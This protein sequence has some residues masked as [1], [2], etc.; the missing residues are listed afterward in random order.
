MIASDLIA[1]EKRNHCSP[2]ISSP[3]STVSTRSRHLMDIHS[4]LAQPPDWPNAEFTR[5]RET[6]PVEQHDRKVAFREVGDSAAAE[7]EVW[8]LGW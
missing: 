7:I 1:S 8:L 3:F 6:Q 5:K 2:P 4:R